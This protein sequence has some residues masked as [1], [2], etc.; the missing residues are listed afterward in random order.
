VSM[1][2]SI[3]VYIDVLPM[4]SGYPCYGYTAWIVVCD[5]G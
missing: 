1:R 3:A 2:S 4:I 5:L